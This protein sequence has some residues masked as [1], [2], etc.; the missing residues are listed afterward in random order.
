MKLENLTEK[1]NTNEIEAILKKFENFELLNSMIELYNSI[2]KM[3]FENSS[4]EEIQAISQFSLISE[5]KDRINL[6]NE[7]KMSIKKPIIQICVSL[8]L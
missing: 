7:I 2:W 4:D 6:L 8:T 5:C 1:V 3:T